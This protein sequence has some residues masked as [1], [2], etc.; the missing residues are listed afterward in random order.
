MP[1]L[2]GF[3]VVPVIFLL[4]FVEV[5]LPCVCNRHSVRDQVDWLDDVGVR[6]GCGAE[7]LRHAHRPY[8][9]QMRDDRMSERL[10][11]AVR[12][13]VLCMHAGQLLLYT[14]ADRWKPPSQPAQDCPT[15]SPR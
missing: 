4:L 6:S 1:H 14:A 5:L 2:L 10:M 8:Y 9:R 15:L 7:Q 13:G 3:R 12:M 11:H